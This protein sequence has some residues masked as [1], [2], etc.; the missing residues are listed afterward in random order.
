MH[1]TAVLAFLLELLE[2]SAISIFVSGS[3]NRLFRFI[4]YI[5][6]RPSRGARSLVLKLIARMRADAAT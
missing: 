1:L 2:T 4:S 5:F 6:L 3:K